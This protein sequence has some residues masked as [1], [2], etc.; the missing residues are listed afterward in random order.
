[1][2]GENSL[3][4]FP[5]AAVLQSYISAAMPFWKPGSLKQEEVW[6]VTAFLLRE[7]GYWQDEE[8]LT[9]SNA[10]EVIVGIGLATPAPTPQQAGTR[11]GNAPIGLLILAGSLVAL[12]ILLFILKKSQNTTT[13]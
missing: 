3:Q 12:L 13:I 8:E 4:K 1:V 10:A 9:S 5:N 2:I 11:K 7:N 6:R